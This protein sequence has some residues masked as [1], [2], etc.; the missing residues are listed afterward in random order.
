MR[1]TEIIR[2]DMLQARH[3][4]D[5]MVSSTPLIAVLQR[6]RELGSRMFAKP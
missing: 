3:T 6:Y 5:G 1:Q 4:I 2:K